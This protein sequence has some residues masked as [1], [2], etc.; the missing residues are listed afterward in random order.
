M[1]RRLVDAMDGFALGKTHLIID[2]DTK[3]CEGFR[4][5]LESA[6]VKI[7]LCPPRVLNAMRMPNGSFAR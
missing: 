5:V 6:G 1:A 7:V 3:Y 4:Q 2:R